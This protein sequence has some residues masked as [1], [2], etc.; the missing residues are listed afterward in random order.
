M[1]KAYAGAPDFP[2]Q[3]QTVSVT[4]W[5]D[6]SWANKGVCTFNQYFGAEITLACISIGAL[7]IFRKHI[8]SIGRT[9]WSIINKD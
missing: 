5:C 4:S 7:H 3:Q 6:K 2:I 8:G 9:A 1:K